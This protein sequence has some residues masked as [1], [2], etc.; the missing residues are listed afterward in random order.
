MATMLEQKLGGQSFNV[1]SNQQNQTSH[2][3]APQQ[4]GVSSNG[5]QVVIVI[6]VFMAAIY[7]LHIAQRMIKKGKQK[8]GEVI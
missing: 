1:T 7:G 2:A 4:Y 6:G 3:Q 5:M 8:V